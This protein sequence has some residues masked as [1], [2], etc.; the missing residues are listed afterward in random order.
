M[1]GAV[2]LLGSALVLL[3]AAVVASTRAARGAARVGVISAPRAE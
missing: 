3:T 2:P 1:P